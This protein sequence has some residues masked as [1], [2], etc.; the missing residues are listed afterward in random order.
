MKLCDNKENISPWLKYD[1][2]AELWIDVA[3]YNNI[4]DKK[5]W[6]GVN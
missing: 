1:E 4:G 3:I 6:D 2:L 5:D